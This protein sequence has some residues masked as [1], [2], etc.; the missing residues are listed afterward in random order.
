MNKKKYRVTIKS[1]FMEL[2]DN[3]ICASAILDKLIY[4]LQFCGNKKQYADFTNYLKEQALGDV[5]TEY[6]WINNWCNSP[7]TSRR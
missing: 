2:L 6:G 3:N 7:A 5:T 4:R 1:E